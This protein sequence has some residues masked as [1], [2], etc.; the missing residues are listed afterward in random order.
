MGQ[1]SLRQVFLDCGVQ[2][3]ITLYDYRAGKWI[4]SDINDSHRETL[5]AS[6]FKILHTLIILEERAV[7]NAQETIPW[8]GH[9]DT[10]KY[11]YRPEIYHDMSLRRAF[12]ASAG[13]A[14]VEQAKKIGKEKYH[15][16]LV[17]ADYG[18]GDLSI[19]D[20][21]FWNF[22]GFGV[23][24]VNQIETLIGVYEE[25]LPFRPETFTVLKDLMVEEQTEHYTLRAKTG[26][27][28]DGGMNTGWWVGYFEMADNVWFF[29]TRL[30]RQLGQ[31]GPDFGNCR[32]EIT[33]RVL[34]DLIPLD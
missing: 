27:T 25:T 4:A 5:P 19:Q 18:N 6:T 13:W 30:H 3:S 22:G 24:P 32:K 9:T 14:Y 16:Y 15:Q 11:G 34:G 26:W 7:A 12:R 33:R 28:R 31:D 1:D 10:V 21:D 2:G 29:A 23:T 8:P 17:A 20:P